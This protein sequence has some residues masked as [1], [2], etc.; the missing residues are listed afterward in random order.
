MLTNTK[1]LQEILHEKSREK[2]LENCLREVIKEKTMNQAQVEPNPQNPTEAS[3]T[4][5]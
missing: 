5:K 2:L 1:E 4:Q 3:T